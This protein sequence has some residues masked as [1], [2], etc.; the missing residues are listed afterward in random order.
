[1]QRT[2]RSQ[3]WLLR[4]LHLCKSVKLAVS[5]CLQIRDGMLWVWGDTGP[6]A[7]IDSAAREP[8][9]TREKEQ[10]PPET[11]IYNIGKV[12]EMCTGLK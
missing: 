9:Y 3:V 12:S 4:W 11:H 6:T 7:F 5:G 2:A 10:L 1:M 8:S